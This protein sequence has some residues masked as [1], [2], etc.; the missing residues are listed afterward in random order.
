M[1]FVGLPNF[2]IKPLRSAIAGELVSGTT[3]DGR[4][5]LA[6]CLGERR[7]D[8]MPMVVLK[9]ARNRLDLPQPAWFSV[10]TEVLSFGMSWLIEPIGAADMS[11][12][13]GTPGL[14]LRN[15]TNLKV[16]LSYGP[17]NL[18]SV[19]MCYDMTRRDMLWPFSAEYECFPRWRI[20]QSA[21]V[22]DDPAC[23]PL[24]EFVLPFLKTSVAA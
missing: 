23:V 6:V 19:D 2:S 5:G 14:L 21:A 4:I 11:F 20:W 12:H 24:F 3:S 1:Q 18:G 22:R 17:D 10:D 16:R 9:G 15:G 13:H 8:G 7:R